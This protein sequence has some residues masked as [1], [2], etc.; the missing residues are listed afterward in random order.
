MPE[1]TTQLP[2][3]S[4]G[5]MRG[6]VWFVLP[7]GNST[8]RVWGSVLSGMERIYVNETLV[9]EQR[10]L[11]MGTTYAVSIEEQDYEVGIRVSSA[12]KGELECLLK[13]QGKVVDVYVSRMNN[14]SQP[15][16]RVLLT[17]FGLALIIGALQRIVEFPDWVGW[18]AVLAAL[19]F[20]NRLEKKKGTLPAFTFERLGT[21]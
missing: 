8:L 11:R 14:T 3:T 15:W 12:W 20:L 4:T 7:V 18:V 6:G 9:H 17:V 2:S 19:G 16:L 1:P 5:S 13:H 10:S 21:R